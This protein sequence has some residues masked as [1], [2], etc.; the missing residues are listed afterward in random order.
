MPRVFAE[1]TFDNRITFIPRHSLVV[2]GENAH[3]VASIVLG[4]D[5]L[6]T[7]VSEATP[8]QLRWGFETGTQQNFYGYVHHTEPLYSDSAPDE[9]LKL[10][11][12]GASRTLMA[13]LHQAWRYQTIDSIVREIATRYYLSADVEKHAAVWDYLASTTSAWEFL[14]ELANKIGYV[15]AVNGTEVRLISPSGVF[16]RFMTAAP[17]I[18]PTLFRPVAGASSEGGTRARR[19]GFGLDP[20]SAQI[21]S[22]AGGPQGFIEVQTDMVSSTPQEAAAQLGGTIQRNRFRHQATAE[23]PGVPSVVQ[24]SLVYVPE[25]GADYIGQWY[26]QQVEHE[27]RP[28]EGSYTMYLQLGRDQLG[29][30]ASFTRPGRPQIVRTDPYGDLT[31][32]PPPTVLAKGVWRSG[33][34]RRA[35]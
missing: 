6:P 28:R 12:I 30:V 29:T 10:V 31:P 8:I 23:A 26:V 25:V 5:V 3:D 19:L 4:H 16:R 32:T 24:A 18:A 20:R 21:Y 11:C 2:Q 13:G 15:V 17:T 34:A 1:A 14:L 33:W 7:R 22:V 35:S 9:R 27:I